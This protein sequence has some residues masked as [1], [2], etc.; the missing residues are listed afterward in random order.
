[1][2]LEGEEPDSSKF[3]KSL[4]GTWTTREEYHVPKIVSEDYLASLVSKVYNVASIQVLHDI[5]KEYKAEWSARE[6]I[7]WSEEFGWTEML[8][9]RPGLL[10][11]AIL[12]AQ[13]IASEPLHPSFRHAAGYALGWPTDKVLAFQMGI[14]KQLVENPFG[15]TTEQFLDGLALGLCFHQGAQAR[16]IIDQYGEKK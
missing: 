3:A 5:G 4:K 8:Q 16:K 14:C 11:A 15:R 6:G 12:K 7:V 13:S 2:R 1:M 10:G 9:C